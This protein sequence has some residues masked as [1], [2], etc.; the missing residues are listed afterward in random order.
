MVLNIELLHGS[1]LKHNGVYYVLR[2]I[3]DRLHITELL[4]GLRCPDSATEQAIIDS[5]FSSVNTA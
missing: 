4:T 3:E 2:M 1:T 5:L